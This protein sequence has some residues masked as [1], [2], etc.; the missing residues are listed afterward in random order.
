[1]V[2]MKLYD[3]ERIVPMCCKTTWISEMYGLFESWDCLPQRL[4]GRPLYM[5]LQHI[6]DPAPAGRP[7]AIGHDD[8]AG[9]CVPEITFDGFYTYMEA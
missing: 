6:D 9:Y 1:M 2:L 3:R 5:L 7:I 8:E 4:G